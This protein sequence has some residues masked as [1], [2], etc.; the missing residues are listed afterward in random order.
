MESV[1]LKPEELSKRF[2][3]VYSLDWQRELRHPLLTCQPECCTL[4]DK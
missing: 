4:S 1:T 3:V 2:T